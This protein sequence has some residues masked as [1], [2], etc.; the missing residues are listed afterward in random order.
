MK[1]SS[2]PGI[3]AS[4]LVSGTNLLQGV[5]KKSVKTIKNKKTGRSSLSPSQVAASDLNIKL[6]GQH[7][8]ALAFQT[9]PVLGYAGENFFTLTCRVN[10]P[11][12]VTLEVNN[13][14]L[15]S[16]TAL[17]H[18]F[19]VKRLKPNT[20]YSYT[21]T[22]QIA[23][24]KNKTVT[25]ETFAVR[26]LPTKA[27]FK[28]AVLGDSRTVPDDWKKVADA[29]LAAKPAFSLFVGDMITNGRVDKMWD[30][31]YC[32]PAKDFLATIP[33]FSVIGNHEGNCPLFPLLFQTP[34]E[35]G[36][37][38]WS[39][40]IGPLLLIGIDGSMNWRHG[41]SLE[42]WLEK[43]LSKSKAKFI[44]V[45]SHYPAWTS[46]GHGSLNNKGRPKEKTI[47]DAQDTIMPLLKKYNV[48]AMFAGHDHFY[49]RS[50]PDN[51]VTMIV[52]GGAGAPLRDKARHAEKQ[53]PFS[54]VFRKQLHFCLISVDDNKCTMSV[55]TP[56]GK[57]IDKRTWNAAK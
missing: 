36:T 28:F 56:E 17:L 6:L 26:T 51:G 54:V 47:R 11:A 45:G 52:T 33:Y 24:N 35:N 18:R 41:S 27:P 4:M 23:G 31:E 55:L 49:E 1:Y 30:D 44:F 37:K 5:W 12:V 14:K 22:A 32:R 8:D 40:K 9:D 15:V 21:L 43:T 34:P 46:G 38:N 3:P 57:E 25:T 50:E 20:K 16:K 7:A 53:N 2:I 10:I 48:T 29:A 13:R 39:Q 42:K 19:I